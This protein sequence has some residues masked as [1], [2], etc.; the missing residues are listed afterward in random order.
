VFEP[1]CV[2]TVCR[3]PTLVCPKCRQGLR[4]FHCHVHA[5]LRRCYFTDLVPYTKAELQ[6][7][8]HELRELI[9]EIAVGKKFKQKRKTLS[10]QCEKIAQRLAEIDGSDGDVSTRMLAVEQTELK[11]RN[12]GEAGC[13][14][15]C[16]GFHGLKRKRILDEMHRNH[17]S[18]SGSV[19]VESSVSASASKK[20]DLKKR[21]NLHLQ[22]Q[23]ALDRKIAV[24]ELV[25][26]NLAS[27]PSFDRN[28]TTGIRIPATCTRMLQSK[29]KGKWCGK[30][31]LS[32]LQGEFA[33]LAQ[34][35]TLATI[36]RR[37]L[38]R[39]NDRAIT[40]LE[41]AESLKLKNMDVIG[42]VAHWHE[43]P[44]HLPRGDIAVHK[45]ALPDRVQEAHDL[46]ED[47]TIFVCDKPSTVPVH[48]A[49]PYLS[50]SLTMMVEAQEALVPKTLIPCHRIDRVTSG[51]TICCTNPKVAHLVQ[52]RIDLGLVKK[53]YLAKVHGRFP[54]TP[55]E[56]K[57]ESSTDLAK[58]NWSEEEA[59]LEV[60]AP[61]ETVDPANGIRKITSQGKSAR[62]LFRLIDHD[63]AT[64]TS[65]V[66]CSPLT[67]RSHQLR[68]HLQWL[69]HSIVNDIQYGGTMD[70]SL[71]LSAGLLEANKRR[72]EIRESNDVT[73]HPASVSEEDSKAATE[74]CP[75]C[76]KGPKEA[77]S[78]SQLL[79]GGHQICLHALR[80]RIPF[81]AKK[82]GANTATSSSSDTNEPLG[83][84]NL[85]VG[86]PPWAFGTEHLASMP[87]GSSS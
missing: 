23:K 84:V 1:G 4:E 82:S 81:H 74:I 55:A 35:D 30:S 75:F 42:R 2:C 46:Q 20:A 69:G 86:L 13:S 14:G 49:G 47:A 41:E 7:Q 70:P 85:Q 24:D 12:C 67:G 87:W 29:T 76:T 50:N 10:K 53:Q 8:L 62:S 40:S 54:G 51:L 21:N 31:L 56:M 15:K 19:A 66:L 72:E 45:I 3:E 32:V 77:F 27:S 78:S 11:C 16:W 71:D 52:S 80:Y 61:V 36:L 26:L 5:H 60:N 59:M 9:T 64:D 17:Q 57:L 28:E 25:Q 33:E 37:G 48:P 73:L 43:P 68:V 63:Q 79:Q 38:L 22:Q 44:V 18:E 65:M 39:V 83:E 6:A 34:I 58:W